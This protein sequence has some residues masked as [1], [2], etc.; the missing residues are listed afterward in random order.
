MSSQGPGGEIGR[1][2]ILRGWCRK[3]SRFESV[4]G[5]T[6]VLGRRFAADQ[7]LGCGY[8][9]DLPLAGDKSGA[10]RRPSTYIRA[11]GAAEYC[12]KASVAQW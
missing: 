4:P 2:A 9:A 6:A 1:H 5:H 7:V 12:S 11:E 3:A 10:K 8:A